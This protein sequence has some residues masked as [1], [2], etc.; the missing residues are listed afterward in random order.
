MIYPSGYFIGSDG[1]VI[2]AVVGK[3]SPEDLSEFVDRAVKSF[4]G[5]P[6]PQS[7]PQPQAQQQRQQQ[8]NP[9]QRGRSD[10][11]LNQEPGT[12]AERNT[13]ESIE[14]K[15]K[16]TREVVAK[17]EAEHEREDELRRRRVGADMAKLKEEMEIKQ[18]EAEAAERRKQKESDKVYMEKLRKQIE[19]DRLDKAARFQKEK[20]E[21]Q[22]K[23]D[24]KMRQKQ[25]EEAARKVKEQAARASIARIQFR[26]P[27]GSSKVKNF[28]PK[29]QFKVCYDFAKTLLP[30]TRKITLTS[31]TP[32]RV[33][34]ND[35]FTSTL[36]DLSLA[37]SAVIMV[38]G[39]DN[40]RA[41]NNNGE[42]FM[43]MLITSF[44]NFL[45]AIWAFF[46]GIIWGQP[47]VEQGNNQI[48]QPT[49]QPHQ[50]PGSST[51]RAAGNSNSGAKQKGKVYRLHD[52]KRDDDQ[53]QATWNGNSTN[54]M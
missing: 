41:A 48:Q 9:E 4:K 10:N 28:E 43:S 46:S 6:T 12:S 27:D 29:D 37:P 38:T 50:R 25:E 16:R 54:Q 19:Q 44:F 32:K 1:K 2:E 42:G 26:L 35:D 7:A 11:N 13:G 53:D 40:S 15:L 34:S 5:H 8:T 31:V 17:K 51:G 45:G 18:R 36:A 49:Q 33:F 14:D 3:K 22:D 21:Q 30:N 52:L 23:Y 24:E 47:A 20:K 39:G